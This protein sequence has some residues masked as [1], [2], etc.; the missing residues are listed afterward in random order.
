MAN[1]RRRKQ[2]RYMTDLIEENER[3]ARVCERLSNIIAH[4]KTASYLEIE[5]LKFT[6][7]QM[8]R[9]K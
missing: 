9:K 2:P 6:I 4:D 8:K 7:E 1:M 5:R 3:L